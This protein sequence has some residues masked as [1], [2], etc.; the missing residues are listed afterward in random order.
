MGVYGS[1]DVAN[2][3]NVNFNY[4]LALQAAR[5][6]YQ[7]SHA[8]TVCASGRA[9]AAN[10]ARPD[11]EGGKRDE[12]ESK[13]KVEAQDASTASSELVALANQF[14]KSWAEARGEQDRINQARYTQDKLNHRSWAEKEWQD[15]IAG[16]P[17]YGGPPSDPPVPS[18]PDFS[19][20]RAPI[21]AEYENK[22]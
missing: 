11:W 17:N 12:F 18:A 20:T 16:D 2:K 14:A 5:D 8:V 19:P 22:P 21:H 4:G 7:L 15:N 13:L 9:A 10:V 3:A 6:L 1:N